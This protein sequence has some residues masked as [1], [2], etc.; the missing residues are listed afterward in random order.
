VTDDPQGRPITVAI[1]TLDGRER[2][3]AALDALA[4]QEDPGVPWRVLVIDNGSTDGTAAFAL[5]RWEQRSSD[6]PL[7]CV[8]E[9][10]RGLLHGRVRAFTEAAEGVVVFVDDDNLLD[11]GYVRTVA[12]I[13]ADRPALGAV[14]GVSRLPP[15]VVGPATMQPLLEAFAIG[16]TTSVRLG[17]PMPWGAGLAVRVEAF[18]PLVEAGYVPVHASRGDDTEVGL[19]LRGMG[20]E[21]A[22]DERLT[23]VHAIDLSR[24]TP[25]AYRAMSR[26]NGRTSLALRLYEDAVGT[27]SCGTWPSALLRSV[28]KAATSLVPRRTPAGAIDNRR[29]H[30][31]GRLGAAIDPVRFRRLRRTILGNVALA[32]A[33]P[34][35]PATT[36]AASIAAERSR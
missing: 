1:C 13:F 22:V 9:H 31:V 15:G 36:T 12:E 29:I 4:A 34:G 35:P 30:A 5:E 8:V 28:A 19:L 16:R 11:P 18:L 26:E 27:G 32:R 10:R 6:V 3:G 21:L 20:W 2:I 24:L 23:M 17:S 14:G 7:T 25:S 33:C